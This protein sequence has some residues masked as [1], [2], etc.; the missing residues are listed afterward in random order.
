MIDQLLIAVNRKNIGYDSDQ[1]NKW[2]LKE[3][4][5]KRKIFGQY[6]RRSLQPVVSYESLSVYYYLQAY[7]NQIGEQEIAKEVIDR[8]KQLENN[9]IH[10]NAHFFDYIHYQYL[11]S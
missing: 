2:L 9:L 8:T 1:L 6:D 7:L 5:D 3:W 10:H 11:F 4:K